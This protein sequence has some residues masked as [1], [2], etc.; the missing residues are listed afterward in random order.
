MNNKRPHFK[1]FTELILI[2]LSVLII[3]VPQVSG[4]NPSYAG[5]EFKKF[6]EFGST[7][8]GSSGALNLHPGDVLLA[9][10]VVY[11]KYDFEPGG[12]FFAD[13]SGA[14]TVVAVSPEQ[15]NPAWLPLGIKDGNALLYKSAATNDPFKVYSFGPN[16]LAPYSAINPGRAPIDGNYF[17]GRFAYW[18]F[19]QSKGFEIYYKEEGQEDVLLADRQIFP[20]ANILLDYDGETI[21]IGSGTVGVDAAVWLAKPDGSRR[22]VLQTGDPLPGSGGTY[23]MNP[24]ATV[25]AVNQDRIY[26]L[27]ATPVPPPVTTERVFFWDDGDNSELIIKTGQA[28][29]GYPDAVAV[30]FE[31]V[32]VENGTVWLLVSQVNRDKVL[33]SIKDGVWTRVVSSAD[34][35]DGIQS[36]GLAAYTHGINGDNAAV[37]VT[38]LKPDFSV[39]NA[40]YVNSD[41]PGFG[42]G[43]NTGGNNGPAMGITPNPDGSWNITVPTEPGKTYTLQTSTTLSEWT[44]EQSTII[45]DGSG[46]AQWTISNSGVNHYY[47]VQVTE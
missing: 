13:N 11:F 47:R 28:I 40:I 41:L 18:R 42:G 5:R 27:A 20:A 38:L 4:Q 45:G 25:V 33:Y 24:S 2:T 30:S 44:N 34:M 6:F 15:R 12:L 23:Q 39:S 8:Q 7:P 26:A 22:L 29:P 14:Y 31:L 32:E 17:D 1:S 46:S 36:V 16:G 21:A 3:E 43:N 9:D 10:S 35:F 19:T 37:L